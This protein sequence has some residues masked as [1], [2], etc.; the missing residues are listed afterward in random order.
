MAATLVAHAGIGGAGNSTSALNTTGATLLI[1]AVASY[2]GTATPSVSDSKSNTWTALTLYD[3]Y[4]QFLYCSNP[5][6]GTGHTFEALGSGYYPALAVAA[7]SGTTASITNDLDV[8]SASGTQPGSGTPAHNNELILTA[9]Y[10][11]QSSGTASV[12]ESFAITDTVDYS[13]G[14]NVGVSLAYLN[15]ATAIALNP[16]WGVTPIGAA[17]C[18]FQTSGAAPAVTPGLLGLL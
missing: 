3:A 17:M 14:V 12:N 15:Q 11:N 9:C 1:A 8:G 16:T 18:S 7:F 5:T 10:R 6:V 4:I 13:S 2:G